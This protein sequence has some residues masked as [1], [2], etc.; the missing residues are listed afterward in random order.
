MQPRRWRHLRACPAPHGLL[1][2]SCL[3]SFRRSLVPSPSLARLAS[4]GLLPW[5][6]LH[7]PGVVH[8]AVVGVLGHTVVLLIETSLVFLKLKEKK[9][10]TMVGLLL[11]PPRPRRSS[12]RRHRIGGGGCSCRCGAS[13]AHRVIVV[14]SVRVCGRT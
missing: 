2:G 11:G 10:L 1:W 12:R 8:V 5:C 14:P 4:W 13:R 6:R 9:K 7:L 3:G